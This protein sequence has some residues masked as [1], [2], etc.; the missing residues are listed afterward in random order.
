MIG[1]WRYLFALC[2]E[3]RTKLTNVLLGA[4]N[5][6]ITEWGAVPIQADQ[7]PGFRRIREMSYP[8]RISPSAVAAV[9]PVP[10]A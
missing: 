6:P 7:T 9:S 2:V 4:A 10:P 1:A 3:N 5:W 8:M